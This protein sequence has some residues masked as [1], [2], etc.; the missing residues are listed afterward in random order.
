MAG[1]QREV[2]HP[3]CV[4]AGDLGE[5]IEDVWHVGQVGGCCGGDELQSGGVGLAV[6]DPV[7]AGLCAGRSLVAVGKLVP[8]LGHDRVEPSALDLSDQIGVEDPPQSL[9]VCRHELVAEEDGPQGG[10]DGGRFA[11]VEEAELGYFRVEV[12]CVRRS[13]S[14]SFATVS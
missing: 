7:E 4:G 12:R 9:V 3:E 13:G 10:E 8:D 11:L 14:T 6:T 1:L 2:D 5:R